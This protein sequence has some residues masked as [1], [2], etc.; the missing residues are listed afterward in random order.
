MTALAIKRAGFARLPRH[1]ANG[2]RPVATTAI[3]SVVLAVSRRLGV[4]R[5]GAGGDGA[6]SRGGGD[7]RPPAPPYSIAVVTSFRFR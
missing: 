6:R 3:C 1:P 2:L 7:R 5:A 4:R